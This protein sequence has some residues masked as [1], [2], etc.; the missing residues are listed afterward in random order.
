MKK[1]VRSLKMKAMRALPLMAG[2][3]ALLG[4]PTPFASTIAFDGSPVLTAVGEVRPNPATNSDLA[5]L[6]ITFAS[7]MNG[8]PFNSFQFIPGQ[9]ASA[10]GSHA[11][12]GSAMLYQGQGAGA[13]SM[14]KPQATPRGPVVITLPRLETEYSNHPDF[15][16]KVS[17]L[18]PQGDWARLVGTLSNPQGFSEVVTAL[19]TESMRFGF[20]M[21]TI[22]QQSQMDAQLSNRRQVP[23]PAAAWLFGSALLGF[24]MMSTRGNA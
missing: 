1:V 18:A 9:T 10:P 24:V 2:V 14:D 20:E 8:S 23:L 12:Q 13:V 6:A 11:F 5:G 15:A 19:A 22:G 3:A 17:A 4:T 16:V 21:P 7:D